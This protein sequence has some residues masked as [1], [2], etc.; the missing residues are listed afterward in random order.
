MAAR[1]Y[2]RHPVV[3]DPDWKVYVE[4]EPGNWWIRCPCHLGPGRYYPRKNDAIRAARLHRRARRAGS[5]KGGG[6]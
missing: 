1:R 3:D 2:L 4:G 5:G 6:R